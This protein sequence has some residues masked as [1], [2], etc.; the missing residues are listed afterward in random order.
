VVTYL[1]LLR[2]PPPFPAFLEN[3]LSE[4]FETFRADRS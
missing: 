4:E 3:G 2:A 1:T